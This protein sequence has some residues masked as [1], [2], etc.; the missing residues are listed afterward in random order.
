[1]IIAPGRGDCGDGDYGGDNQYNHHDDDDDDDDDD[2][3]YNYHDLHDHDL[4]KTT[5]G[6]RW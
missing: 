2:D 3:W 5:N 1:M 4:D 6:W